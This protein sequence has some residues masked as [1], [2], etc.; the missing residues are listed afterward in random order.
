MVKKVRIEELAE[1]AL[2]LDNFALQDL[3]Q[4]FLRQNPRLDEVSK[5]QTDDLRVLAAAASL[6]ELFA[7]R[8]GQTPPS[9]TKEIGPLPE[10]VYLVKA[11]ATG[12]Y[13]RTLCDTQAPEPLRKRGFRA[14]P[15]F[16]EF[17]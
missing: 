9:W 7:S 6:L 1:A 8:A 10:K 16:L 17:R 4:E 3:A 13:T 12:S 5:P 14:P 15:N 11:A 2:R